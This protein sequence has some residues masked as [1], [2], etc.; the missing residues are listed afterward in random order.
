MAAQ[1]APQAGQPAKPPSLIGKRAPAFTVAT[2][3]GK[4][5][6]LADYPGKAILVN[7]WAT[8][9]P[10][11]K[12]E[13][14][15]LA[16]LREKYAGQG[17]EVLGI[18]TNNATPEKIERIKTKYDIQ[19]PILMCNHA[20]AQAYGGLPELPASFFIDRHGKIVA[21]MG[22]ADSQDEIEQNIR[23]ALGRR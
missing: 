16:Q 9:C 17:F 3:D 18:L 23:K 2:L 14:P 22:S 15:W 6:Q 12:V 4:P 8:W 10:N 11:C 7:F 5:V 1:P 20:T 13:M 19:Y 21:E